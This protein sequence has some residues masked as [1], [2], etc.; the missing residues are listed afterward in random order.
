MGKCNR[1]II[2]APFHSVSIVSKEKQWSGIILILKGVFRAAYFIYF[3]SIIIVKTLLY[4]SI[5]REYI[6][7]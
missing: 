5:S 6:A 4:I 2:Y 7:E 3:Y 1:D